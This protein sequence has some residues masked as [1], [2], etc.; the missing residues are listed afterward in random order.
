MSGSPATGEPLFYAEKIFQKGGAKR[1]SPGH[2]REGLRDE[3]ATPAMVEPL[4]LYHRLTN[5][6]TAAHE[7]S[8]P[9]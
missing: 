5:R 1:T 8:L 2:N 6:G 4:F 7:R 3:A 9:P